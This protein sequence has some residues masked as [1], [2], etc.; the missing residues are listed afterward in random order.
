Q[1]LGKEAEAFFESLTQTSPTSVRLNH[2][3][4]RSNFQNITPVPWCERGAYLQERPRFHLD[5][6]WHGGAYYVQEA[7]SM[8]LDD[9]LRQLMLDD[10]PRIWLDLCAA[11]GGKTGI[12]SRH[13]NPSDILVA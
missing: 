4:G 9:V 13:L 5:P 11:P 2:R 7:S 3:K 10:S 8:I 12:L 1:Q 6:H